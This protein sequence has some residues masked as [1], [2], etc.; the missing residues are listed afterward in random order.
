M[1]KIDFVFFDA[2]GGHR[3]AATA[4]K[5][6]SE[7][8]NR[9]WDVR[10][11]NL[12]EVMDPLDIFRKFTGVRL[13]D[14]YNRMLANG[15][16]LGSGYLLPGMHG[17][18]RMYHPA[19]VRMLSD[20][21]RPTAPDLVVSVVPNFNRALLHGLRRVP[22]KTPFATILTD[23][24]DFPPHFWIERQDQYLI[25][26]T[27]RAMFQAR[28]MGY[29]PDRI[30]KTSGMILRPA[31]YQEFNHDKK[32]EL[33]R[34]GLEPDRPTGLVLFGGQG[35]AH[36]TRIAENL[37]Q[38]GRSL[39]LI[40][41][42]GKNEKLAA[43]LQAMASRLPMHVVGFTHEIPYYMSLSDF[44]I[45]K[46]GPGSISE[47]TAMKLPVIIERNSWTL[48]QE[49]YN[50]EWVRQKEVGLVVRNFRHICAAVDQLLEPNTF[51]HLRKNAAAVRN[52]SVFEIPDI[53]AQ[54]LE[55]SYP[56]G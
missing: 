19:Q 29:P 37:Q 27:D 22:S 54:I 4:L 11:V 10:L 46:P 9:P 45:G 21:W 51:E 56:R 44:F 8:Q 13:Q 17:I 43:E 20:F 35:S 38:I 1:R 3:S 32:A 26:G 50:A 14:I 49:R 34:L 15:W 36:M 42:C 53:L 31:F 6:V 18:I 55:R 25:C 41:I 12:Q 24:A 16:T 2:G 5:T 30:F 52:R 7:N 39:Q 48:P 28:R 33:L 40:M 47:A 23:F